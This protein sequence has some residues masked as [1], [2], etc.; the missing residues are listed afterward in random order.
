MITSQ[1][2]NPKSIVIVGGSEDIHKPG[3]K[4]IKNLL[5]HRYG[6][7]LYVVNPKADTIQG[8]PCYRHVDDLPPTDMAIISLPAALCPAAVETLCSQKETKAFI[9]FSAGFHEES[10]EGAR[11]EA[12]IV[13]SVNRAGAA[14]IGPNCIGVMNRHYAGVFTRP[15]PPFSPTGVDLISG[16]G[17]TALF[18]VDAAMQNGITFANV[19][20][21]GNSA[22]MGVEDVLRELDLQYVAG[23]SAAVKLLYIE[24]INKP[25]LLLK[26][27]AS[28]VRK[29]VRI[30]A[31]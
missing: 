3:G 30:A 11:L 31:I 15:I 18:I 5:E 9:I 14:L 10:P 16:S 24:S 23:E 2:I 27:A 20:S 8:L 12:R 13:E 4:V 6:G 19:F 21:V 29:G 1:L 7:K 26:H 22:Q 28:L 25:R 17:A